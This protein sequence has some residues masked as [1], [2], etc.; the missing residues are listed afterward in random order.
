MLNTVRYIRDQAFSLAT[1]HKK[2]VEVEGVTLSLEGVS[3]R[4][5]YVMSNGYEAEDA[6]LAAKILTS[7]DS[8]LEAGSAI[9]FLAVYCSKLGVKNYCC[10]EANG[11]LAPAIRR[12]FALNN[13]PAPRVI[14]AAITADDGEIDFGI[15]KNF[16]SSSTLSRAGANFVKVPARSLPSIVAELPF[17]PNVLVMDIEGGE[18]SI[19]KTHF[20]MFD[21][22]VIETHPKLVGADKIDTLLSAIEEMGFKEIGRI[23]GSR[24]YTR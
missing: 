13:L 2:T 12:N 4:M 1:R 18:V 20:A 23:G 19:P 21:K 14:S 8:V 22:I 7:N 16:W 24:A 17:T 9:G 3:P 10:V 15:H 11:S 6:H 5:R